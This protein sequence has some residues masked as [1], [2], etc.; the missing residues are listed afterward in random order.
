MAG[1]G[2]TNVVHARRLTGAAGVDPGVHAARGVYSVL[3]PMAGTA[4]R[5][6]GARRLDAVVPRLWHRATGG[7]YAPALYP[8][9]T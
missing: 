7:T 5:I 3:D 2:R 4:G 6:A 9:F 8:R 1:L